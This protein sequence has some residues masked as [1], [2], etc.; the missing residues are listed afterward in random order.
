MEKKSQGTIVR[1]SGPLVTV[2]G[3]SAPKMY[4]VVKIG[5]AGLMGEIIELT[6]KIASVQVYEETAGIAPGEPAEGT[7]RTMSVELGPGLLESVYDG[8]QRPLS[9]IEDKSGSC[10]IA[11]GIEAEGDRKSTRL[12]SSHT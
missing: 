9:V 6:G 12:N 3:L 2:T 8:I 5:N 7:G 1:V 4:E 11:R 10:Y